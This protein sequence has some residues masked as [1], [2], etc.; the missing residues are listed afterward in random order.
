M[1]NI[2]EGIRAYKKTIELQPDHREAWANLA[3]AQKEVSFLAPGCMGSASHALPESI[4]CAWDMLRVR[5]Q[6]R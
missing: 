4:A 5:P 6:P 3:Q 2:G 1:G